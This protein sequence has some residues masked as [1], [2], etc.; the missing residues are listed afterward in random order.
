MDIKDVTKNLIIIYEEIQKLKEHLKELEGKKK[1]IE[2]IILK[3]IENDTDIETNNYKI[4][5]NEK[6][7][8]QTLSKDFLLK[9]IEK[10]LQSNQNIEPK[11]IINY[12][13]QSREIT[14]KNVLTIKYKK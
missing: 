6:K 12:L 1:V 3:H 8:Y 14:K 11:E 9:T 10:Y 7:T 13:Y 2:N 4:S 5:C